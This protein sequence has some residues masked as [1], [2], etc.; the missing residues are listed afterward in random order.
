MYEKPAQLISCLGDLGMLQIQLDGL[1]K[2]MAVFAW[3]IIADIFQKKNVCLLYSAVLIPVLLLSPRLEGLFWNSLIISSQTWTE[4][5]YEKKSTLNC[6]ILIIGLFVSYGSNNSWEGLLI[7]YH[8]T[9]ICHLRVSFTKPPAI[10]FQPVVKKIAGS[11][12]FRFYYISVDNSV[13]STPDQ[14]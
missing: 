11:V 12:R 8:V 2:K 3:Y 4:I 5:Y 14:Y 10:I 7:G 6:M 9:D 13:M 1:Q